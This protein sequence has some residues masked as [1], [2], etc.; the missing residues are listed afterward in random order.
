MPANASRVVDPVNTELIRLGRFGWKAATHS[1]RHQA[2]AALNTDIGVRTSVLPLPDC[3]PKQNNCD[4]GSPLMPDEELD[5]LVLYLST[6]GVR[7]QR[8]WQT[9]I[10]DQNVL[11]GQDLFASIGCENCH[12]ATMQ[13]SAF[14]PL[15]E[16]RDQTIHPYS[17]L[18]LHDMGDGLA[19]NLGEGVAS[20]REWRTTPLWGLGLAACVTGGVVN[21]TGAEGDEVCTPHHAYLHDGRAR[22]ID[23]AIR[24]HG[25][26]SQASNDEYQALPDTQQQLLL[27]F[28]KS[29]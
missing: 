3:G 15:A 14:H 7:P 19:D 1:V 18:L 12:T 6:L 2:A 26:E 20:G 25:G 23:E 4:N 17:D 21:P 10:E 13:T 5:K 29:L 24:W 11:R 8:V 16:V 27:E 9:G 28:L 22:S